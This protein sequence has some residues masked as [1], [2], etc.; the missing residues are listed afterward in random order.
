M[1]VLPL[2]NR[3]YPTSFTRF[4]KNFLLFSVL[5]R[6]HSTSRKNLR[7][8]ERDKGEITRR[9][10]VKTFEHIEPWNGLSS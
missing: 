10:G 8:I 5:L 2:I 7:E 6:K 9:R 3:Y 1:F 4:S